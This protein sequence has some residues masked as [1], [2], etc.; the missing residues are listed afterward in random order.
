MIVSALIGFVAGAIL[1]VIAMSMIS[2]RKEE[3][4]EP[5]SRFTSKWS[6]D[7]LTNPRIVAEYLLDAD[8]PQGARIVVKQCKDKDKLRGLNVRYNPNVRGCFAIGEDRAIVLAGPF[9]ENVPAMI[10]VEKSILLK[11]N[12]LFDNYWNEGVTPRNL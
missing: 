2:P 5:A 10:T 9:K 4:H 12:D 6:L 11:L 1:A 7:S 8:I 3:S